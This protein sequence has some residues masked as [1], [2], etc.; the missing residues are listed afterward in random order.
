MPDLD[1]LDLLIRSAVATYGDRGPDDDLARRILNHFAAEAAPAR[2]W[3]PWAI[4]LPIAAGLVALAVLSSSKP[5]RPGFGK[6][7]QASNSHAP[8]RAI[9][10]AAPSTAPPS[11]RIQRSKAQLQNRQPRLAEKAARTA[12]LPKLDV[13]PTPRPLTSEEKAFAIFAAEAPEPERRSL[14]EAQRRVDAPLTIAVIQIQ[15]LEPP[16]PGGN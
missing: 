4:A 12:P 10:G 11:A 2:R 16:E 13:F 5:S 8:L 6:T 14:I 3:L 9:A 7:D 1:D 15:P